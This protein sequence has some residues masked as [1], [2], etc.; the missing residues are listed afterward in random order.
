MVAL[1]GAEE[2]IYD[3]VIVGP[4][5]TEHEARSFAVA[6]TEKAFCDRFVAPLTAPD[7]TVA[8]D[9]VRGR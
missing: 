6:T 3:E 4:F 8:A 2:P 5:E 7:V 9:R 1:Y